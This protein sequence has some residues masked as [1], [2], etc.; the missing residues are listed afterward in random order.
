MQ[1]E[2]VEVLK[3][4]GASDQDEWYVDVKGVRN[5]LVDV[6]DDVT[7]AIVP[8]HKLMPNEEGEFDEVK[9]L[10][11]VHLNKTGEEFIISHYQ[12]IGFQLLGWFHVVM[13]RYEGRIYLKHYGYL[14]TP[15]KEQIQVLAGLMKVLFYGQ[16]AIGSTEDLLTYVEENVQC[17]D[18]PMP[19]IDL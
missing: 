9:V 4:V 18:V 17:V 11:K 7:Q 13:I 3:F 6:T 1:I 5:Y 16:P 19:N 2:E 8:S 10:Q 15:R 14:P 12:E